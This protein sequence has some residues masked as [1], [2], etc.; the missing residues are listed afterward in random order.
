MSTKP[1]MT[2]QVCGV[3]HRDRFVRHRDV[4]F[5][6]AD[7]AVLDEDIPRRKVT[8]LRVD[9]QDDATFDQNAARSLQTRGV[10]VGAGS[11]GALRQRLVGHR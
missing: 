7:F 9:A 1:G 2:M 5:D 6:F 8:D 10:P 3:D 11:V 4:R